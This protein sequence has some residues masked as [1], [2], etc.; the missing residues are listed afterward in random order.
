MAVETEE[1]VDATDVEDLD[2]AIRGVDVGVDMGVDVGVD[3]GVDPTPPT[4][5]GVDVRLV[6][7]RCLFSVKRSDIPTLY[8][9]HIYRQ[10]V[11][12]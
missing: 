2:V 3:L 5:R 10:K 12:R 8:F 7:E 1:V 11:Q 9:L 4:D 6:A